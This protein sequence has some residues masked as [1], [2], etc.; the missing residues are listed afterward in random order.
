MSR[1]KRS[2]RSWWLNWMPKL[3]CRAPQWILLICLHRQMH[4]FPSPC[5]TQ[6]HS[7]TLPCSLHSSAVA[8]WLYCFSILQCC[9][10]D[11]YNTGPQ[12]PTR[13]GHHVS[14]VHACCIPHCVPPWV[15]MALHS[16]SSLT[17]MS[18][19]GSPI[20]LCAFKVW[21]SEC[22]IPCSQQ[23]SEIRFLSLVHIG[24]IVT[25]PRP[26]TLYYSNVSQSCLKHLFM[27][28]RDWNTSMTKY[29]CNAVAL[30]TPWHSTTAQ[31]QTRDYSVLCH[32]VYMYHNCSVR[33]VSM[34]QSSTVMIQRISP[35]IRFVHTSS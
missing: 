17:A 23:T 24:C 32:W 16:P 3:K 7:L 4:Q 9:A 27:H 14:Y 29:N 10:V 6:P 8:W 26:D 25:A 30:D 33:G 28:W 31:K 11:H 12:P 20:S 5:L 19:R 1:G 18:A 2:A 13:G 35:I 15:S 34:C 21:L 22:S